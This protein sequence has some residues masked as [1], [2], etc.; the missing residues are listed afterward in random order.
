MLNKKTLFAAAVLCST[1]SMAFAEEAKQCSGASKFS[2]ECCQGQSENCDANQCSESTGSCS[3]DSANCDVKRISETFGHLIGRNLDTPGLT[4]D[5]ESVIAGLRAA[6]EG[7]DAPMTEKEYEEAMN[8]IQEQT[9]NSLAGDNLTQAEEFLKANVG[10]D[11]IVEVEPGKLQY[12]V[13]NSGEGATV[14]EH[15]APTIHYK[16]TYADGTVFGSSQESGNPVTLPLD[17]TIP[18]FNKGLVGMKEGEKRRLYIHPDMGYGTGGHLPP[19]SLLIFDVEIVTA[20]TLTEA[21]DAIAVDGEASL[22]EVIADINE[23]VETIR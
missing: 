6:S 22:E 16:G 5:L 1:M 12:E 9:F 2:S 8:L 15:S 21:D 10:K 4:F 13:L 19:N 20:D 7:R 3:A 17:Q 23:D 11:N 18:G 14:N